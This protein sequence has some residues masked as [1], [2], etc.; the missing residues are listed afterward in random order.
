MHSPAPLLRYRVAGF[1]I[2]SEVAFPQLS[3]EP[4]GGDAPADITMY[5]GDLPP[6]GEGLTLRRNTF[7]LT[8]LE[9]RRVVVSVSANAPPEA[10]GRL[11]AT[12]GLNGIAYQRRLLPLHAGAVEVGN[13]CVAFC[14]KIG[15]GKSTLA[16]ALALAGYP[17][18]SDDLLVAHPAPDG[19]ALVWPAITRPKL[20]LHGMRLL[21]NKVDVLTPIA[22]WDGKSVTSVGNVAT[23][24]PRP[25]VAIYLLT[26]G[27]LGLRRLPPLEAAAILNL[28][29]RKPEW[30]ERSGAAA[31]IRR[32]WLELAARIP[33]S[34]ATRPK[35]S[36]ISI[37]S[38]TLIDSWN[39]EWNWNSLA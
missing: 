15:A 38:Q 7:G 16:S 1:S 6:E 30:L 4:A 39:R 34:L 23:Y 13:G 25:L 28:C 24:A 29:L 21:G 9:G 19:G 8:A 2:D 37:L 10:V 17:L 5:G 22:H 35:D 11:V 31:T 36:A 18:V 3:P 27:E 20:T 12:T 32:Q 14:G 33:I 26:W